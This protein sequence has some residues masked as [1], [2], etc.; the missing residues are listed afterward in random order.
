M[1]FTEP[2]CLIFIQINQSVSLAF[3]LPFLSQETIDLKNEEN[4]NINKYG[5][6][7]RPSTA[8]VIN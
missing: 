1:G 3:V 5:Q 7:S 2:R 4:E 6:R 8:K